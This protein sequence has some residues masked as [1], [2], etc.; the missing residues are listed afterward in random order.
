MPEVV[1]AHA[2]GLEW[3]TAGEAAAYLKMKPRTLLLKVPAADSGVPAV[4]NEAEG[5]AFSSG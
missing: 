3:L 2:P 4:G 1:K 5:L